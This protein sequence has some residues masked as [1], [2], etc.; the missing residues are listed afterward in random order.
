VIGLTNESENALP[1]DESLWKHIEHMNYSIGI[2]VS[3]NK[4]LDILHALHDVYEA[5]D[6]DPAEAK[7]CI[8]ALAGILVATSTGDGDNIWTEITVQQSTKNMDVK[9]KE[10]LNEKS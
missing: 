3:E 6:A 9:L 10:I 7:E 4:S 2:I 5:I 1:L 8:L